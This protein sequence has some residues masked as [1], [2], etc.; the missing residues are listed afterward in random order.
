MNR[1]YANA[2]TS[3]YAN[4]QTSYYATLKLRTTLRSNFVVAPHCVA[5][6][7]PKMQRGLGYK[8]SNVPESV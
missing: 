1:P 3:Y 6:R 4:A 5:Q 2:Q 7:L 8:Q